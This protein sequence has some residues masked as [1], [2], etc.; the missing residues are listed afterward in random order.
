MLT[1]PYSIYV[2]KRPLRFA[3][4]IEDKPESLAIID[5]ILAYNRD[6][7]GGRYNPIV[8]TDGQTL[9]DAGWSLLEAVDP[10][11]VKSFVTISDNLVAS[12]ERRI[13]PYPI[14]QADRRE[15]EDGYQHLNLMDEG[16]TILPTALNVRMASWGISESSF[17]LFETDWKKTDP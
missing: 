5:T 11:V 7:W 14:Q 3:F 6:R 13:S 8:I 10:D 12:I 2:N 9:T 17:V 4:L 16:L 1:A 15:Q